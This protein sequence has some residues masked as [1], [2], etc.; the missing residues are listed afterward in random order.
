MVDNSER[1]PIAP[2]PAETPDP[3]TID[4]TAPAPV[5]DQPTLT[6][7]PAQPSPAEELS[8]QP[9]LGPGRTP[10]TP[11]GPAGGDWTLEARPFG[12]HELLGEIARGGMGV[13][14]R[15]RERRSGRLVALKMMLADCTTDSA[16]AQRFILEAR[17][18]GELSHP[19]IVAIHAWGQQ[20]GQSFYTMDFVPGLPLNRVLKHRP[21]P[22]GRA[23]H[24]LLGIARAV[25]AAHAQGI[26]H[27]DL[28]PSNVMIDLTDQPRVLDF[29]LA[30]RLRQEPASEAPTE[31]VVDVLPADAE[32]PK[33]VA[34]KDTPPETAR[35]V[36]LGTPS[37]MAPEQARG[38]HSQVG[39]PADVFALGSIFFEM[40]AGRPPFE[41]P[42][43]M[44]TLI[45]VME[46]EP[47]SL[48]DLNPLVPETLAA[49][50]RR[51]LAKDAAQRY[52]DAGALA[53]D[54]ERRWHRTQQSYRF[55]RLALISG[56]AALVL[57]ALPFLVPGWD[58]LTWFTMSEWAQTQTAG[59]GEVVQTPARLLVPLLGAFF[60]QL[61]PLACEIG[62][63][64]WL[65]AWLWHTNRLEWYLACAAGV[66]LVCGLFIWAGVWSF[67]LWLLLV[68]LPV[69]LFLAV[70]HWVLEREWHRVHAAE[71]E[72]E[73]YLQRL[74]AVGGEATP[75]VPAPAS[76]GVE[77][78]DIEWG[79]TVFASEGCRV[80]RGRQKSLDRPVLVWQDRLPASAGAP[81]PGVVVHHPYVLSLHAVSSGPD[82]RFLV[83]EPSPGMS[84][85]EVLERRRLETMESV[86][87]IIKMAYALQAFH[88]QGACH[89]R[90]GPDWVLVR[91][92][93]EPLLCPCG[94]PSQSSP[95]RAR[96][97]AALGRL[98]QEWLPSRGKR[99]QR[100][101]LA[102]LYRVCD[103]VAAGQYD[104]PADLANDLDRAARAALVRRRERWGDA[105]G[106]ALFALPVLVVVALAGL[107]RLERGSPD[108]ILAGFRSFA[109]AH[110]LLALAPGAVVLGFV[111]GRG[112]FNRYR[113]RLR[114]AG[115]DSFLQAEL[116][117]LLLP[118][119]FVS[120]AA[121]LGREGTDENRLL[122]MGL[123]V[124]EMIGFWFLG[125]CLTA[126]VTFAELLA[127][128]L[129]LEGT[130]G[131]WGAAGLFG[132][133]PDP[134]PRTP[135]SGGSSGERT[136]SRPSR[137][138]QEP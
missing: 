49:F 41:A 89:G 63:L 105:V 87:L 53:D 131:F 96:D 31:D 6:R 1:D 137:P 35:G 88:N 133:L 15:A 95:E 132:G 9:T 45:Q 68:F 136:R 3:S 112:Q 77:L 24:Y 91:G 107:E 38:E 52:P 2:R 43:V 69:M 108:G 44:D 110:L 48:R 13:V 12:E 115:Q 97:V 117:P 10:G 42:Q 124:A 50:C 40:L 81:A 72:A 128:S 120:L 14:Y 111:Q 123:G 122:V 58:R 55:A 8:E 47:P 51:C 32:T 46:K 86:G 60:L 67:S 98:L 56:L 71:P 113:L 16:D 99:W 135:D 73:P 5:H 27:R 90:L 103:A 78:S 114:K 83:T 79:R 93:L 65:G 75:G 37:Y 106:L 92:D 84:L 26:V 129:H 34:A 134:L 119:G 74:F 23:V 101:S 17:A 80:S 85:A 59:L 54:L 70:T 29:G 22:P 82:G 94:V 30:K 130:R 125:L 7:P 11:A 28:K 126:L 118:L 36:V 116:M 57:L 20:D 76:G 104:R 4:L 19:G 61:V 33:P 109:R 100:H 21:I 102:P 62:F 138:R 127:G 64:V 25:A 18:T 39:P 66:G 121:L